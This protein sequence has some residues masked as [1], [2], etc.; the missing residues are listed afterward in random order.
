[1]FFFISETT[2]GFLFD[3]KLFLFPWEYPLPQCITVNTL[4]GADILAVDDTSTAII[5]NTG[6]EADLIV[7]LPAGLGWRNDA[8]GHV[9]ESQVSFNAASLAGDPLD[10]DGEPESFAVPYIMEE[11]K[12]LFFGVS[13]LTWIPALPT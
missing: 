8:N 7:T 13:S 6:S 1:M 10:P 5:A 4:G 9:L 3:H 2:F 11:T 12:P